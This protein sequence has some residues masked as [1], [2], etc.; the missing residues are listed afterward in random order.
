[1]SE[2]KA[3]AEIV[4]RYRQGI[5]DLDQYELPDFHQHFKTI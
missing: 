1:M 4:E 5:D 3:I 2:E